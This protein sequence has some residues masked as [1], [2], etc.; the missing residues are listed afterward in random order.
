MELKVVRKVF[1]NVSTIGDLMIDGQ[2]FC[3][4]L[5]DIDRQ[6][7]ADNSIIPWTS[8]LKIPD[9]TAIP[10]DTYEV[11]IDWSNHFGRLMPHVLNVRDFDGIRIHIG[12]TDIDTE[13]CLLLGMIEGKDFISH[14]KEA[15]DKFFDAL[16]EALKKG[17]VS[18]KYTN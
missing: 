2:F 14:S 4:T 1:D 15:F 3:H 5:E 11:I 7:Q 8:S 16:T 17:K 10:Y 12:N 9:Q 13:G 6:R 18:I